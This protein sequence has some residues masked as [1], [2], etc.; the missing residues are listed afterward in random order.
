MQKSYFDGGLFSYI[1]H[2]L[3]AVA[4]TVFTLGICTPWA[5]V[6]MHRWK[7]KHTVIDGQRLYFDG[8]AMQLFGQWIKWFLLTIITF[9][10]YGFWLKIKMEQWLTM[11]THMQ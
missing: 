11:H 7:I 9:G 10:I 1:V 5:I 4:I 8:T 3:V 6:H 2:S